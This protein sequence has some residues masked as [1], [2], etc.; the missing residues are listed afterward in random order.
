[1]PTPNDFIQ[2]ALAGEPVAMQDTFNAMMGDRIAAK[3][4]ALVP[5]VAAAFFT[6]PSE[7]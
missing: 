2:A 6:S 1:M 3:V 5:E 4:D 7:E